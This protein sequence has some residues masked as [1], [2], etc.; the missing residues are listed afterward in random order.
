MSSKWAAT[1]LRHARTFEWVF[2][3]FTLTLF[4]YCLADWQG[5]L[6]FERGYQ[7]LRVA[8]LSAALMTQGIAALV[9]PRSRRLFYALLAISAV[10][11]VSTLVVA[12]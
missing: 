9:R 8:L 4:L 2:V 3:L 6:P 5:W 10:L 7:P 11:L 1:I 12:R